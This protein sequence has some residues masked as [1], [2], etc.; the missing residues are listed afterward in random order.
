MTAEDAFD[1]FLARAG[2]GAG[3]EP[4]SLPMRMLA[5]SAFKAGI[6]FEKVASA[7]DPLA[8]GFTR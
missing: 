8:K 2:Y 6:A 5:W 3:E 7:P 4:L 1:A